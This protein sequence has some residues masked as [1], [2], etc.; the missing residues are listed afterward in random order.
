MTCIYV[1]IPRYFNILRDKMKAVEPMIWWFKRAK[2]LSTKCGFSP[3]LFPFLLPTLL[4]L[5]APIKLAKVRKITRCSKCYPKTELIARQNALCINSWQGQRDNSVLGL[6]KSF[7]ESKGRASSP[8]IH[9]WEG[10]TCFQLRQT[11]FVCLLFKSFLILEVISSF[12]LIMDDWS[13]GSDISFLSP[14]IIWPWFFLY[15]LWFCVLISKGKSK[16]IQLCK[17]R[18]KGVY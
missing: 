4:E 7:R 12:F 8:W 16:Q 13:L 15:D 18:K 10:P 11:Q 2:M 5:S 3:H 6:E 17:K 9:D 1:T 14:L